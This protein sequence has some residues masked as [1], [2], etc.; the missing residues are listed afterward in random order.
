[1]TD[2]SF[3][4]T[5]AFI[6]PILP[7]LILCLLSDLVFMIGSLLLADVEMTVKETVLPT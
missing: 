4:S 3:K 7:R 2:V 1:M 6:S 5:V